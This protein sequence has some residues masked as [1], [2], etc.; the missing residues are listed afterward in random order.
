MQAYFKVGQMLT[1]TTSIEKYTRNFGT[2]Q[3]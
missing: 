1:A 2:M 3:S